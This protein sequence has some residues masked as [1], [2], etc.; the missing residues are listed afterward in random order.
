MVEARQIFDQPKIEDVKRKLR[1]ELSGKRLRDRV[2]KG[3]KIAVTA[4][5]RGIANFPLMLATIVEELKNAG[6]QP[7]IVPSMGSHGGATPEGQLEV[8]E[9]L[10]VTEE[11]VGAPIRSSMEVVKVGEL[12]GGTPVYMDKFASDADG[13]LVLG[14]VKPHTDFKDEIESGLMK[15][16]AI[17]LGKQFGAEV[18]HWHKYDGYHRI[19]PEAA[20]LIL[21][22]KNVVM[23]VAVVENAW[24]ETAI[25]EAFHPEEFL[26]GEKRLLKEAKKLLPRL[27]FRKLD[28]LVVDEIGKNIS[29]T[30]MDT[31]VIGRFWMPG[32]D[33]PEAPEISKIV[34]LGL[35]P[36]THGNAIG[37][38]L[39]DL[40]TE[41]VFEEMD[42][43]QT[44]VNCLTQGSGETGRIPPT[45]PSD[46]EAIATAVRICGPI[47]PSRVR[48][49]RIKNTQ[50]LEK[51]W[52]SETLAD[53]LKEHPENHQIIELIG[54]K[55]EM[56]FDVLGTLAR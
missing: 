25:L 30:G 24:H 1:E 12:K 7:F 26:E 44:Y 5:S 37:I 10:G 45:L 14:R 11:S 34:V 6:A 17:G 18:I 33:D 47:E 19:I 4:G 9:S 15:M 28:V 27:P 54:E 31:N 39:A 50:D 32:E 48:L 46:R 43:K 35:S 56:Q 29:G 40:T 21:K 38:G 49:L 51:F 42:R 55:K 23:G 22:N 3:Q 13:V 2:K 16:L 41:K 36:E 53:E 8:L 52:V 20:Q